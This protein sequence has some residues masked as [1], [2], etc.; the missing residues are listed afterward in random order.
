MVD[1]PDIEEILSMDEDIQ[2]KCNL[3]VS[4]ANK[5]GGLDNITVLVA[6]YDSEVMPDE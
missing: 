1:D 4:L 2:A 3:L 5:N 6:R